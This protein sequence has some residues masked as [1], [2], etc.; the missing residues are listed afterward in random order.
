MAHITVCSICGDLFEAGSEECANAPVREC[1]RCWLDRVHAEG[2]NPD[3][4]V[5][6][7]NLGLREHGVLGVVRS[8]DSELQ[9]YL[10]VLDKGP[11]WRGLYSRSEL[12]L[13]ARSA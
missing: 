1:V 12:V 10:V 4:R 8:Y 6:V 3:D 9:M 11:P 13:V 5:Q 2:F 7:Y